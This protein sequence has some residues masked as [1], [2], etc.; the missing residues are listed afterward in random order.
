[1]DKK[2]LDAVVDSVWAA[3]AVS[4]MNKIWRDSSLI[5]TGSRQSHHGCERSDG[6][7]V[8]HGCSQ[9]WQQDLSGVREV[10]G[11]INVFHRIC[12]WRDNC[13]DHGVEYV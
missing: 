7:T 10:E 1:M 11:G 6:G 5:P 4:C 9:F 13:T 3:W 12:S 8:L 2:A